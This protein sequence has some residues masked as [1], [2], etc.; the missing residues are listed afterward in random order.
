MPRI[1]ATRH[2]IPY[3]HLPFGLT[4]LLV[5]IYE[6]NRIIEI[7]NYGFD[8]CVV[9]QDVD[10][11]LVLDYF[12]YKL[13]FYDAVRIKKEDFSSKNPRFLTGHIFSTCASR[14]NNIEPESGC[15]IQVFAMRRN[16]RFVHQ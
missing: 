1:A 4:E 13:V 2:E 3:E 16:Q 14:L 10:L 6:K 7:V 9:A 8:F 12:L 11:V 15:P 5:Y